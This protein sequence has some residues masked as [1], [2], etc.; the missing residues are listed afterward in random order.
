MQP[1]SGVPSAS[2]ATVPPSGAGAT[3]A[4]NVTLWPDA[5]GLSL[6]ARPVVVSV[7]SAV[8]ALEGSEANPGPASL[9]AL[10]LEACSHVR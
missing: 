8:T 4:V 1:L 9:V 10:T 2:N 6:L 5:D 7:S 3:V